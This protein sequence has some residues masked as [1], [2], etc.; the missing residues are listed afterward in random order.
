MELS[1]IVFNVNDMT[2][3]HCVG[4]VTRAI[5]AVEPTATVSVDLGTKRVQI[6]AL[7]SDPQALKS[8]IEDAGYTPVET[9]AAATPVPKRG[10]GC[11][12]SCH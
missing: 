9:A 5:K 7:R 6:D 2:C 4:A 10:G 11:C 8:A 12:G 1:M 3:G